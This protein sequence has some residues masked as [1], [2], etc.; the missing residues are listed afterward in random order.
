MVEDD[1]LAHRVSTMPPLLH[2]F[3]FSTLPETALQAAHEAWYRQQETAST[4][5]CWD[6]RLSRLI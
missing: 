5:T 4:M 3:H 6:E 2:N 1:S